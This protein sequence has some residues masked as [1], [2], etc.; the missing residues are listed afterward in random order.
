MTFRNADMIYFRSEFKRETKL[1]SRGCFLVNGRPI[2]KINLNKL[3]LTKIKI[4]ALTYFLKL[5]VI[6]FWCLNNNV[7]ITV[8]I[9]RIYLAHKF[10][11]SCLVYAKREMS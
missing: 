7:D 8:G 6:V 5:L 11:R 2:F 10:K 4:T 1:Q 9:E 3:N